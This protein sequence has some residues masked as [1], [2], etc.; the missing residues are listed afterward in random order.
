M[1]LNW[2][3]FYGKCYLFKTFDQKSIFLNRWMSFHITFFIER[4]F[5]LEI[6]NFFYYINQKSTTNLTI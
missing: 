2:I 4:S 3:G 6:N 1:T 5:Q